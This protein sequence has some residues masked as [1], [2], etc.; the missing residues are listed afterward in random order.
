MQR[1]FGLHTCPIHIFQRNWKIRY[2]IR[3]RLYAVQPWLAH[4]TINSSGHVCAPV[5]SGITLIYGRV[6]Q[7]L[8]FAFCPSHNSIVSRIA[9][10]KCYSYFSWLAEHEIFQYPR[11]LYVHARVHIRRSYYTPYGV[12]ECLT[13]IRM[14]VSFPKSCTR[15]SETRTLRDGCTDERG[16]FGE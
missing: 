12:H 1:P 6:C 15:L 4:T 7:C 16:F 8:L 11:V 3:R 13:F 9:F 5:N 10:T 14:F 2:I